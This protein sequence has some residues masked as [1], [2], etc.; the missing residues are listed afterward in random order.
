MKDWAKKFYN[1]KEWE[2]CREAYIASRYGL[3]ERCES[4]GE[5]VHHKKYLTQATINDP[6]ITLNFDNLELLCVP[7]H[8][9]EHSKELP[10]SDEIKFDEKG[11][12]IKT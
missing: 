6:N 7:C 2:R 8:N 3:C 9:K 1:S 4:A 10:I 11:N 12:V 5:I